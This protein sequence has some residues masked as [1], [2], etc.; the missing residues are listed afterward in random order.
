MER[1]EY[2]KRMKVD[3]MIR[4]G[5][6]EDPFE[7][8]FSLI[9]LIINYNKIFTKCFVVLIINNGLKGRSCLDLS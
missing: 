7:G 2:E 3:V 8:I 5:R 6:L 1:E 4:N 9:Q